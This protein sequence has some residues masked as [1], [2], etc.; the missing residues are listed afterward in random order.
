MG[1]VDDVAT[2][3]VR[4]RTHAGFDLERAAAASGVSAEV[5]AAAESGATTLSD[6]ELA[7]MAG[8]YGVDPIEIFGGRVTPVRDFAGGA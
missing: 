5:L 6:D 2:R 1:V 7:R 8:A 4:F 3:L